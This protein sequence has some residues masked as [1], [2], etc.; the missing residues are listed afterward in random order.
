L[1]LKLVGE[2]YKK[3]QGEEEKRE[4]LEFVIGEN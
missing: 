2:H 4:Y 1:I 3:G